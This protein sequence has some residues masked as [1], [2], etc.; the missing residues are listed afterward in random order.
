MK[1]NEV[2][3]GFRFK[4]VMPQDKDRFMSVRKEASDIAA[5]YKAYPEFVDFNWDLI[6]RDEKEINMVV[7]QQ[8]ENLFVATCSI[9]KAPDNTIELAYDV[10][11]ELRGK[12]IGTAVVRA[13]IK[14]AHD[15]FPDREVLVKI[16][17]ENQ[18]SQHVTE[19]CGGVFIGME[20]S[21]E[22][23]AIQALLSMNAD[24]SRADE[25][26]TAIESGRNA[27]MVYK[28]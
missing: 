26:K 22:S 10:V 6:L 14:L 12:G 4:S 3:D 18:V 17:K 16:R 23:V 27:V 8:P 7:L 15:R 19:K 11:K 1:I 24:Y 21:P 2:V 28:V 13:L 9:L 5:Y 25:A 20:A